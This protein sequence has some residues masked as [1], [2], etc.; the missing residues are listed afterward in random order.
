MGM[1]RIITT[2][3]LTLALIIISTTTAAALSC[4]DGDICVDE[5]SWWRDG[6]VFNTSEIPMQAAVDN[7]T[8]GEMICA[9]AESYTETLDIKT[10]HLT[11]TG[12]GAADMEAPQTELPK[13]VSTDWW[14]AVQEDIRKSEYDV[15]WQ[16][17]VH[18]PDISAAY[19][20]PNRAH[21]LRTYFMPDSIMITPRTSADWVFGLSLTGYGF[22]DNVNPVSEAKMS[23]LENRVEYQ[24]GRLTEWYVNSEDG[25]EQGFTIDAPPE[26]GSQGPEQ[27]L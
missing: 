2:T 5:S 24:R 23:V 3:V 7:A 22:A 15:I 17:Y 25:I 19:K 20:A 8:A 6:G 10:P 26:P 21:N 14:T 4:S 16:E 9:L 12:E 13:E 27:C 18:I 11:L 1:E